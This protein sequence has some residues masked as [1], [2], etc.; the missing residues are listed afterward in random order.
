MNISVKMGIEI[1]LIKI[2]NIFH[3]FGYHFSFILGREIKLK[4]TFG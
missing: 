1:E 3:Q 4:L 2:E